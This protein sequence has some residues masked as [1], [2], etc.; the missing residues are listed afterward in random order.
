MYESSLLQDALKDLERIFSP[1]ADISLKWS[2]SAYKAFSSKKGKLISIF[3]IDLFD[4]PANWAQCLSGLTESH[5]I[6]QS[7]RKSFSKCFYLWE[8]K[9]SICFVLYCKSLQCAVKLL[10]SKVSTKWRCELNNRMM[11]VAKNNN[12][13]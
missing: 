2:H 8:E 3:S 4:T 13:L 9:L 5:Y 12:L 10:R 7:V 1:L 6:P 11:N